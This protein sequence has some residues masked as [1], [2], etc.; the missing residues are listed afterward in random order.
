[1][2]AWDEDGCAFECDPEEAIVALRTINRL[3]GMQWANSIDLLAIRLSTLLE[4]ARDSPDRCI[5]QSPLIP[6]DDWAPP[7]ARLVQTEAGEQWWRVDHLSVFGRRTI[8]PIL[9]SNYDG[10]IR[11]MKLMLF[12]FGCS[13]TNAI[14]SSNSQSQQLAPLQFPT[15]TDAKYVW[16]YAGPGDVEIDPE[17]FAGR[18]KMETEMPYKY[19]PCGPEGTPFKPGVFN[20]VKVGIWENG[21]AVMVSYRHMFC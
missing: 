15:G 7:N 4:W 21:I 8:V 12:D 6:W 5:E 20:S 9:E 10:S 18:S 13:G 11:R 14:Y 3:P 2:P 1:M 19:I 17:I 16:S